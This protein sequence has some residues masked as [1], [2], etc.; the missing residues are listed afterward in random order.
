VIVKM[1]RP[2]KLGASMH[3]KQLLTVKATLDVYLFG[4]AN[5]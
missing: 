5:Y 3:K 2:Q 1:F 4:R